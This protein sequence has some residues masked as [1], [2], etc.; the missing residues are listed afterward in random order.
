MV[1]LGREEVP[2]LDRHV[3]EI[4]LHR[5]GR[6]AAHADRAVIAKVRELIHMTLRETAAGLL[7]VEVGLDQK[8]CGNDLVSRRIE[9]VGVRLMRRTG[10]LALAAAQA[11]LDGVRNILQIVLLH[12]ERLGA[13]QMEARREGDIESR[14]VAQLAAV[15]EAVRVHLV[16]VLVE[17]FQLF[18]RHEGDLCH[19]DTVFARNRAAEALRDTHHHID[20]LIGF[21]HHVRI[22]GMHRN[23]GVHVAVARMHMKRDEE[24]FPQDPVV[25]VINR[26]ADI[27]EVFTD[28]EFLQGILDFAAP[29]HNE[30]VI[31]QEVTDLF[32]TGLRF[33]QIDAD[34][35]RFLAHGVSRGFEVIEQPGPAGLRVVENLIDVAE[36]VRPDFLKRH[37][38]AFSRFAERVRRVEVLL[39][40]SHHV[41]LI[42]DRVLD[43]EEFARVRVFAEP[44]HRDH[45]VFI[46]LEGVRVAADGGGSRAFVPELLSLFRR[47]RDKGFT[48]AAA[49]DISDLL[50]QPVERLFVIRHD[51]AHDH[52]L[53]VAAREALHRVLN[54]LQI[55][56]V[57]MLEACE[58]DAFRM[59]IQERGDRENG[60]ARD[61]RGA[62]EFETH[63]AAEFRQTV[64]D[65]AGGRDNAVAAFLLHA[66]QSL[67]VLIRNVLAETGFAEQGTREI[68]RFTAQHLRLIGI[69]AAV[70]HDD[71]KHHV[72]LAVDLAEIVIHAGDFKPVAVR[73]HHAPPGE[74]INRGAPE[75]GLLAAGVFRDVAAYAGAVGG[76]GVNREDPVILIGAL[77]DTLRD[78]TGA[79]EDCRHRFSN[80]RQGLHFNLRHRREL[81]HVHDGGHLR[82]RHGAARVAGA[83]ASADQ[84]E[85]QAV[86]GP[87]E[88]RNLFLFIRIKHHDRVGDS[89]V[90]RVSDV[91]RA[92]IRV[93]SDIAAAGVL[94]ER[95][96]DLLT[97][98]LEI[99]KMLFKPR[100]SG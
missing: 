32:V 94:G 42:A 35:G 33:G 93:E 88:P 2:D 58:H 92:G 53:R 52:H 91:S 72:L 9:Q 68:Q 17:G 21:G 34:R 25:D 61:T 41:E 10:V 11:V 44:L 100:H 77:G 69:L 40:L 38:H 7:F 67:Q 4:D 29:G 49:A 85:T 27:G 8:R 51:V 6:Q 57:E 59:G 79:R 54:R 84:R 60:F 83:A 28:Q 73:V 97:L 65:P 80:A 75:H 24:A 98:D 46:Q 96:R 90:R 3:T 71:L 1:A 16:E 43:V 18:I 14:A 70:L 26:L 89:P 66:G 95:L 23:I 81:F 15:E 50:G 36:V 63:C 12:E 45:D 47:L 87:D 56:L 39:N 13:Q 48:L 99:N 64:Q 74:V 76:S 5:A 37:L 30:R 31:Q 19:A 86:A 78:D 22:I 20:A 62:I 82:E 55:T